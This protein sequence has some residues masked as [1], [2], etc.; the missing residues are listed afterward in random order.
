MSSNVEDLNS[1]SSSSLDD[2]CGEADNGHKTTSSVHQKNSYGWR[3]VQHLIEDN[4]RRRSKQRS[5][6]NVTNDQ[7]SGAVQQRRRRSGS[8]NGAYTRQDSE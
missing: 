2:F 7:W 8:R 4:G 5:N 1:L 3:N 6:N